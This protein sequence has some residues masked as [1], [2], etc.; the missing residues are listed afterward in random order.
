MIVA[1]KWF[2]F[3]FLFLLLLIGCADQDGTWQKVQDSGVL[4]VGIDP[5]FP[6]FEEL[7]GEDL[8]GIDVDLA[9]AL[10]ADLGI[11]VEF[12]YFGYDGLYG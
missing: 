4:K 8:A 1:G 12:V 3:I 11:D 5:T 2:R 9:N 6:P 10:G 7:N